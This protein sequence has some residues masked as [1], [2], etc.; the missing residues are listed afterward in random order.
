[1]KYSFL[2]FL[3]LYSAI[4]FGQECKLPLF[5]SD[6]LELYIERGMKDWQIP[7]LS[8]AIVKDGKVVYMKGFGVT[9]KNGKEINENTLFMIGSNTKAFTGAAIASLH[10]ANKMK[11]SDKVIKWMPEFRLKDPIATNEIMVSD[12]LS[13]QTGL[14]HFRGDFSYWSSSLTRKDVI[15]KMEVVESSH[16]FRT[17][18]GYCNSAYV[19]AGEIIPL[20]IQKT[21]EDTVRDS[22]LNPLGMKSTLMLSDEIRNAENVAT[23]HSFVDRRLTKIPIMNIDNLG[24]AGSM[25]SSAKDMA[26]WL[27]ALISN[28]KVGNKQLINARI[29]KEIKRPYTIMGIDNRDDQITHFYLY[30]L[31]LL[32]NDCN[33]K[34]LYYHDGGLNGYLSSVM[35]IPED[36]LGIVVLTNNDNNNF[37]E[38]LAKEIRNAFLG[39]PHKGYSYKSLEKFNKK[40]IVEQAN[41]DS[42]KNIVGQLNKPELNFNSYCGKYSNEIYG[43]IE[44]KQHNEKL[45]IKFS[46]HPDLV[47]ELEYIKNNVFLCT[48]SKPNFGIVEIPFHVDQET[49]KGLTLNVSDFIEYY[50]YEF[51]KL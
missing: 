21:W 2:S 8:I 31:G 42:L 19:A 48:Y 35:V 14:K 9:E 51:K 26:K 23:P 12:L 17:R 24:P 16:R 41:I 27:Q 36:Q 6:S 22:I 37:Y 33:G 20:I 7:G 39:L 29:I 38:D 13:H 47:G 44:V 5:I 45:L 32:V 25:S 30:G 49:V 15:R 4:T 28:G 18:F 10:V 43:D 3:L 34:L 11:L 40:K 1:M 46:N 50:P